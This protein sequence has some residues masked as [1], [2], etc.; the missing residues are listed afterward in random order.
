MTAAIWVQSRLAIIAARGAG[1][2]SME[3]RRQPR[4]RSLKG[5]RILLN[6]HHS[7]IDCTVRNFSSL[8]ACLEVPSTI[9]IPEVFDL[10]YESDHS[11]HPCR[12]VW[13][14]EQRLGVEFVPRIA[15][16]R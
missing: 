15:P 5:A 16:V 7:V 3:R 2:V 12:I 10:V 8:G 9:G 1:G 11:V 6:H 4:R 13:H 14:R